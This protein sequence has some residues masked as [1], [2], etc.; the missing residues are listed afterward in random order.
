MEQKKNNTKKPVKIQREALA[1]IETRGK[2]ATIGALDIM[3]KTAD[4]SFLQRVNIGSSMVT[5]VYMG[6]VAA[7]HSATET[8]RELS[9]KIGTLVASNVIPRPHERIYEIINQKSGHQA[10]VG[11]AAGKRMAVGMIE[12]DSF[13]SMIEAADSGIKAANVLIPGWVTVG[14]GLT[15]VFFRGEVAAVHSAV[16]AGIVA[17]DKIGNII[18]T[19]V[20]PQ[21]HIG[22][23]EAAP[24]GEFSGESTF[25][26]VEKDAALGILE[27][28]GITSLVEGID[29]GLKAANTVVQGW[30]KIG[31]GVTSTI[32]RGT[33]AD[34][35]SSLDA[36]DASA[37]KVGEVIG[38]YV[39]ARP[40][41]ELE[42]G[43]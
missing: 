30:E 40:H 6:E 18:S 12:T 29:S 43:R 22:T 33:V 14:S 37:A 38:S 34:V 1:F 42:K 23:E 19:H 15:T 24:I 35:R 26:K 4:V 32:F 7:A 16:E 8:A 27:T 21:P 5:V 20:I 10:D 13:V 11:A 3:P 17:A 25:K 31:R 28:K 39:I 9:E 41:K 36:A 2:T